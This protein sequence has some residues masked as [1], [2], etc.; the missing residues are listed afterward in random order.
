MTGCRVHA[1]SLIDLLL[2]IIKA[3]TFIWSA[4][5]YNM[6]VKLHK[7]FWAKLTGYKYILL[8]SFLKNV[9]IVIFPQLWDY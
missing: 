5:L 3:S 8:L 4:Y 1:S 6:N 7:H 9:N 2:L